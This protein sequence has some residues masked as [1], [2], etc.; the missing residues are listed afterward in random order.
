MNGILNLR[1][2]K[3]FTSFDAVAVLRGIL[4]ERRIG[5]GGTLDPAAEGVLVI[6]VGQA[7]KLADEVTGRTKT[8]ETV[9]RLGVETDTQDMT[10]K[11]IRE[12][13]VSVTEEMFA[14]AAASFSGPQKQ[15]PP[16]YSAV[17]VGGKRLYDLARE[18]RSVER[19]PRDVF[20][21][22][23]RVTFFDPPYAG[24]HVEC[25]KG[26]YIRT[27]CSDI[28]ERLGC[29]A[30]MESLVR[31][32]CGP[33]RIDDALTLGEIDSLKKREDAE[34]KTSYSFILPPETYFA[35]LPEFRDDGRFDKRIRNGN[36]LP[37]PGFADGERM[38]VYFSDGVFAGTYCCKKEKGVLFP[39]KLFLPN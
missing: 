35:D 14:A 7:T 10:G 18:G 30:A 13:S 16:M 8:Y 26:T 38:R 27:L 6:L 36:P 25:S 31:T 3:D 19:E 24:L 15:V 23:I 32:A 34:G 33:F 39:D 28:G 4:R 17:K 5:H 20:F 29:G 12:R 21:H 37:D 1:K 9:L 22:E 11:V 2:E